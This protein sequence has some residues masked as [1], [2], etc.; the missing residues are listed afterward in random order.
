[1]ITH[2]HVD[3][4]G[5]A[6]I[7]AD[8]AANTLVVVS[9]D[10]TTGSVLVFLDAEN[11]ILRAVNDAVVALKTHATA[12][13]TSGFS[14]SLLGAQ[15]HTTFLEVPQNLFSGR[16]TGAALVARGVREV[17]Q[18]QPVRSD[19]LGAGAVFE[20]VYG[21]FGGIGATQVAFFLR[22]VL[23]RRQVCL[24]Q[25]LQQFEVMDINLRTFLLF[26]ALQVVI[27]TVR[28]NRCLTDGCRQQVRANNV[29]GNKVTITTRYLVE[30]V[31]VNQ[32]AAIIE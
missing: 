18:E 20:V 27:D 21:I 7:G 19:D 15:A 32:T 10:I 17:A 28:S 9:V 12:H 11:S 26:F 3:V 24:A 25:F 30:G 22:L 16:A 29:A 14:N 4:A 1:M 2:C 23:C 8:V 5:R 31:G 13:A 6:D